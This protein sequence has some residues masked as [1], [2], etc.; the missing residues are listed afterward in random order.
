MG[1]DLNVV[2][3]ATVSAEEAFTLPERLNSSLPVVAAGRA[4]YEQTKPHSPGLELHAWQWDEEWQKITAPSAIAEAWASPIWGP[5]RVLVLGTPG[6]LSIC[7][8]RIEL[9]PGPK[10]SGFASN[11]QGCQAPIRRVC[12][13]IAHVLGC[14]RVLYLPDSGDWPSELVDLEDTQFD[15]AFARLAAWGPPASAIGA[16]EYGGAGRHG[17]HYADGA[18]RRLDGTPA[19]QEEISPGHHWNISGGITT[20]PDGRLVPAEE[21]ARPH[22]RGGFTYYV[23]DFHDLT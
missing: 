15:E 7:P 12:R 16:L 4:Y 20:Y 13:A 9:A 23:D 8:T 17:Y 5:E 10:L 21:L 11:Y 3:A 19:S 1:V 18:L 22:L 6:H 2:F 14:D